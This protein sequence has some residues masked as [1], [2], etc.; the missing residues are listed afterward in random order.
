MDEGWD[1]AIG[2][3]LRGYYRSDAAPSMAADAQRGAANDRPAAHREV[4]TSGHAHR[5]V[6][7]SGHAHRHRHAHRASPHAE[8]ADRWRA[9]GGRR[10][11]TSLRRRVAY[12]EPDAP[13]PSAAPP[14]G[15]NA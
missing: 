5:E 9:G 3:R 14:R 8:D 12:L 6:R 7:T 15:P 4:R 1:Q 11:P 2:G 13:R 10:G